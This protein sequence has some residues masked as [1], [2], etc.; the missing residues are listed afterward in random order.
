MEGGGLTFNP[1]FLSLKRAEK[2]GALLRRPPERPQLEDHKREFFFHPELAALFKGGSSRQFPAPA[3]ER[4]IGTFCAGW[5][6]TVSF[7]FTKKKPDMERLASFDEVWALCPRKPKPGW[8]VFGR[9]VQPGCFVALSAWPKVEL[10]ERYD[11]AAAD[12][13]SRWREIFGEQEP[14]RGRL[15]SDYLTG[16]CRNVDQIDG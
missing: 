9:F 14:Y 3:W 8:R 12:V 16:V 1:T 13:I 4:L 7:E 10:F 6:L 11:E 2:S 15:A 5:S